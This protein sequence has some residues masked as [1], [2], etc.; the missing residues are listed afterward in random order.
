MLFANVFVWPGGGP[1]LGAGFED[2]AVTVGECEGVL[3]LM[4][5]WLP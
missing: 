1:G 4:S 3:R 2:I 5:D